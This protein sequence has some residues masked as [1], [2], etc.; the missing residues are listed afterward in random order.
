MGKVEDLE[1]ARRARNKTKIGGAAAT[2]AGP[3]RRRCPICRQPAQQ[4]Y[5]PF[6]SQRCAD[7]DLGR[8][9]GGEYRVP[10]APVNALNPGE[11]EDGDEG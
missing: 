4:R 3:S 1:K 10:G 5:R 6:C 8:W 7:V 11:E 9:I 2:A